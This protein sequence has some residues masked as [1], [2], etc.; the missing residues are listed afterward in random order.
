MRQTPTSR[1]VPQAQAQQL[2]SD[3][4][5]DEYRLDKRKGDSLM[6][7]IWKAES[8]NFSW[9]SFMTRIYQRINIKINES[10]ISDI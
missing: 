5:M 2:W 4:K 10:K 8:A 6:R 7:P 9:N 1:R 3:G